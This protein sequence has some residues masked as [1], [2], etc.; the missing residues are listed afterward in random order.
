MTKLTFK[1]NII[2]FHV[3]K[4]VPLISTLT[5]TVGVQEVCFNVLR[6]YFFFTFQ[7]KFFKQPLSFRFVDQQFLLLSFA[8]Y[9]TSLATHAHV[10]PSQYWKSQTVKIYFSVPFQYFIPIELCN[11]FKVTMLVE[12]FFELSPLQRLQ[13]RAD[14]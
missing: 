1:F 8:A 10:I 7:P 2:N 13:R 11:V 3:H 12:I 4:S 9:V 14:T 5:L 6:N